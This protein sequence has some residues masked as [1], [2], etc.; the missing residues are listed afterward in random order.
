MFILLCRFANAALSQTGSRLQPETN[1]KNLWTPCGWLC[2]PGFAIT[3]ELGGI[4]TPI[5]FA[6]LGFANFQKGSDKSYCPWKLISR[7]TA[8]LLWTHWSVHSYS[9]FWAQ[10]YSKNYKILCRLRYRAFFP[11]PCWWNWLVR[12]H[13]KKVNEWNIFLQR[14]VLNWDFCIIKNMT[15][16]IIMQLQN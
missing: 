5:K 1:C 13:N 11:T 4:R 3:N 8:G 16:W 6:W 2:L 7:N 9:I 12:V 10:R 15:F 14:N